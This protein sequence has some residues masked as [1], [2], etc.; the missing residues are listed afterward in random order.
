MSQS[1]TVRIPDQLR[2][3]LLQAGKM[4]GKGSSEIVR[5]A[6]RRYLLL[7]EFRRLRERALPYAEDRGIFTDEDVFK[8]IS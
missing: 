8:R 1:L 3:R 6:L 2:K 4:E 7:L 5:E